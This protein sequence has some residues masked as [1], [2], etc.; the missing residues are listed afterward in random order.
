MDEDASPSAPPPRKQEVPAD[1]SLDY[2]APLERFAGAAVDVV[3]LHIFLIPLSAP[4]ADL[5]F[6]RG[7]LWPATVFTAFYFTFLL[8]LLLRGGITP[9]GLPL[10]YR[11]RSADLGKLTWIQGLKRLSPYILIQAVGLWRLHVVLQGFA[12][13]G[14]PYAMDQVQAIIRDHGGMWNVVVMA[15]NSFV[16]IDLLAVL[17][18]PRNQSLSDRLA[19]SVAVSRSP[20]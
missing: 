8:I 20:S 5:S 3:F 11:V 7:N 14:E 19:R 13:S 16:L 1:P 4:A 18:S 15:L 10:K 2:T 17:Q 12:D 6:S 9:G